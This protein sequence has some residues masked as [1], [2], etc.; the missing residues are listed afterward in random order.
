MDI[1][2]TKLIAYTIAFGLLISGCIG[3]G[4]YYFFPT[5]INWDWYVGIALFFLIFEVGIMLFVNNASEKKDK[6]QMVNIY[7]LTKVVKILAALVVIGIFA[8]Y[9]KENLKG[10]VAVFILLY[11]LYLVAE[12]SL[13]V[14]IEKHIKEKK[15]KDE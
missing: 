2:K 15:S 12:T 13:F 11:L 10:F 4:L 7:M 14:K 1:F 5:L 9:D 8:F 3:V 6:K